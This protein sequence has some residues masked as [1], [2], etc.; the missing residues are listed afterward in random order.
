MK[1]PSRFLPFL[2]DSSSFFPIF[3]DF[4]LFFPIFGTFFVVRGGTL[5]PLTPSGY[6]TVNNIALMGYAIIS[7]LSCEA[8]HLTCWLNIPFFKYQKSH[9]SDQL[10]M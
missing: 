2:P 6:A 9:K 5:L 8:H 7:H 1:E 10:G 3:P 4:F